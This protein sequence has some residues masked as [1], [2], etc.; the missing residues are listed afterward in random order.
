M[1]ARETVA[2]RHRTLV[3]HFV[4]PGRPHVKYRRTRMDGHIFV[5]YVYGVCMTVCE[6]SLHRKATS[7][8]TYGLML[9]CFPSVSQR[10]QGLL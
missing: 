1:T 9:V 7:I 4:Q 2:A 10:I 6:L 3:S 5:G 8:E